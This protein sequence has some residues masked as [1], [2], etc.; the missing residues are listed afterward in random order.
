MIAGERLLGSLEACA[1]L[2]LPHLG[3]SVFQ[4]LQAGLQPCNLNPRIVG[5]SDQ[6]AASSSGAQPRSPLAEQAVVLL[7][8]RCR[9][10]TAWFIVHVIRQRGR[11]PVWFTP[12]AALGTA[13]ACAHVGAISGP[14]LPAAQIRVKDG[15]LLVG[16]FTCLDKQGNIILTNT[17]EHMTLNGA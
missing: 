12:A 9:V 8:K 2:A 14:C 16:E 1:R 17:Y 7:H 6:A 5:M 4:G 15:R 13:A 10:R 11:G 3:R